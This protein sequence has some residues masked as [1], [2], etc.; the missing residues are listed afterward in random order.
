MSGRLLRAGVYNCELNDW[1]GWVPCQPAVVATGSNPRPGRQGH[2][3]TVCSISFLST[4][5][6]LVFSQGCSHSSYRDCPGT[7][8]GG[9]KNTG[10]QWPEFA[11]LVPLGGALEDRAPERG[12]QK[13]GW[14]GEWKEGQLKD[15][16]GG[17]KKTKGCTLAPPTAVLCAAGQCP[18]YRGEIEV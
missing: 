16:R 15:R 5:A 13:E 7:W 3:P 18:F 9:R 4:L 12:R 1:E 2:L 10:F 11:T 8:C 6:A 14:V 17:R